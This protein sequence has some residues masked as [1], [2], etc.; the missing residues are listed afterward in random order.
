MRTLF[1]TIHTIQDES[2]GLEDI[3]EIAQKAI[4]EQVGEGIKLDSAARY[5][6]YDV[7]F[8][9]V[10]NPPRAPDSS[11]AG[12]E[13][14]HSKEAVDCLKITTK[15]DISGLYIATQ[16]L[17]GSRN[18][19][20]KIPASV[21]KP[22]FVDLL[23]DALP[24][25]DGPLSVQKSP[26]DVTT[27]AGYDKLINHPRRSL[28]VVYVAR[29][30]EGS[31]GR[32]PPSNNINI[33]ANKLSG[34]AHL[35]VEDS[36]KVGQDIR[37]RFG[38]EQVCPAGRIRV[39]WPNNQN[40]FLWKGLNKEQSEEIYKHIVEQLSSQVIPLDMRFQR[41]K[42]YAA[43]D[44]AHDNELIQIFEE[45][46]KEKEGIIEEAG[47]RLD[48][49]LEEGREY[50]SRIAE[51]E[52]ELRG[53]DN[54]LKNLCATIQAIERLYGD[55]VIVHDRAYKEIKKS[56]FRHVEKARD[57]VLW[58]A[59]GF[60][61]LSLGGA[62]REQ[63]AASCLES[64][65]FQYCSTVSSLT[66]QRHPADYTCTIGAEKFTLEKHLKFGKTR[67]P[68]DIL[69]IGFNFWK[70]EEKVVIGYIG[71]HQNNKRN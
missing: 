36:N 16:V 17:H 53:V 57:A 58:L 51:L 2:V 62:T 11:F 4:S 63:L 64:C 18:P 52:K 28:P 24:I 22:N 60:H 55:R 19:G 43:A 68:Q 41:I 56:P 46:L 30:D 54:P 66:R 29:S 70:E 9:Q 39:Y 42:T 27:A 59:T 14:V 48:A 49:C 5:G 38:E 50:Q 10:D 71:E 65:D 32:T 61:D 44:G 35:A 1:Q 13:V 7:E 8:V 6:E 25:V 47:T 3:V 37:E 40:E 26:R 21:S 12:F 31:R 34:L 69:R 23:V 45:D 67:N 33:L 20:Q 15:K